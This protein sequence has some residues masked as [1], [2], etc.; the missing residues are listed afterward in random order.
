M[1]SLNRKGASM[2]KCLIGI[3]LLSVSLA[4][5]LP[6]GPET[7]DPEMSA[8][9][10]SLTVLAR[11]KSASRNSYVYENKRESVFGFGTTTLV[12][13]KDGHVIRREITGYHYDDDKP[14]LVKVID[15]TVIETG[16]DL[17]SHWIGEDP[18]TLDSLYARCRA[19]L[20]VDNAKNRIYMQRDSLGI[21]SMCGHVEKICQDD[22]FDGFKLSKVE[23]AKQ[24]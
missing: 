11:M 18:V 22:C 9:D 7:P 1:H 2:E 21:L 17:G 14:P 10:S 20:A 13:V 3:F 15:T 8:F 16:V 24:P 19:S 12:T 23:W 4:G 6:N 5:C